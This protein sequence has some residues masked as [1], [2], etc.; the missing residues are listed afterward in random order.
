MAN[1]TSVFSSDKM[2]EI[3]AV[4]AYLESEDIESVVLNQRDSA[5]PFGEIELLVSPENETMAI[6][7]INNYLSE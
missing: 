1:W 5:Y 6:E 7:L 3:L 4:K 2:P